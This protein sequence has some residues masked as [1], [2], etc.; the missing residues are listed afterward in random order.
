MFRRAAPRPRSEQ[1]SSSRFRGPRQTVRVL[2]VFCGLLGLVA[3]SGGA[4]R[5]DGSAPS[6]QARITVAD[7]RAG[8]GVD[9]EPDRDPPAPGLRGAPTRERFL[10]HALGTQGDVRVP[11]VL[12]SLTLLLAVVVVTWKR[13][14]ARRRS[15]PLD[16]DDDGPPEI[17]IEKEAPASSEDSGAAL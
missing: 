16:E 17:P 11:A 14:R 1:I 7:A 9:E 10:Q 3:G 8:D 2:A 15:V 5:L 13:M 12:F 4:T 6:A